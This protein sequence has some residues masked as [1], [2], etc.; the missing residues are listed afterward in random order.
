MKYQIDIC[1]HFVRLVS[2]DGNSNEV[3]FGR[4][5]FGRVGESDILAEKVIKHDGKKSIQRWLAE[6]TF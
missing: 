3:V 4:Y 2:L 1:R 5:D 6:R